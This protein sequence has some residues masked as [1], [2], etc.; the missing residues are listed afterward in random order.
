MGLCVSQEKAVAQGLYGIHWYGTNA[1]TPGLVEQMSGNQSLWV[2]EIAHTNETA[3]AVWERLPW[4]NDNIIKPFQAKGHTPVVRLQP[5]WNANVPHPSDPY[6]LTQFAA[7]AKSAAESAKNI[8]IWQVGN[9]ANVCGENK[10]WNPAANNY[11]GADW[12]PTARQ[13]AETYLA[14]R[15]AIHQV[16]P[17][18]GQPQT[19]LLEPV[20]PGSYDAA[21]RPVDG[22]VYLYDT[23]NSMTDS[24]RVLI[25]GFAVH[26]YAG[27]G[28]SND[29]LNDF[30]NTLNRQL[31]IIDQFGLGDKPVFIT[32]WNMHMPD[33]NAAKN[34]ARF[35][36]RAFPALNSQNTSDGSLWKGQRSH[37]VVGAMWFVYP[38][39]SDTLA[40]GWN[41]YSL[42]YWKGKTGDT[43]ATGDPYEAFKQA[44][45]AGYP[46]GS[47]GNVITLAKDQLWCND[48]FNNPV[49]T[50]PD[51]YGP[52][53]AW[54]KD[55]ANSGAA[56]YSGDGWLKLGA[57]S[58]WG[59]A[60]IFTKANA[61]G[62]FRLTAKVRIAN[63]APVVSGREANTEIRVRENDNASLGYS[64]TFFLSQSAVHS[65]TI[66]VRTVGNW[67]VVPGCD[68]IIPG[69]INTGDEFTVDIVAQDASIR[70]LVYRTADGTTPVADMT[71]NSP[72]YSVGGI[73]L[74]NYCM[75]EV[76]YDYVRLGGVE[77]PKDPPACISDWILSE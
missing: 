64:L 13:Y 2:L 24:E 33:V 1:S 54:T 71:V 9:E 60:G 51:T 39:D 58:D 41:A 5:Y 55:C 10:R 49:G 63:G 3:A 6:G 56:T 21:V 70:F 72:L 27:V 53:P 45:I 36:G 7:D 4:R 46:A 15:E 65:G 66:K 12:Q 11:T 57:S 48:E 62:N 23:L 73:R 28:S 19:C 16:V 77:R 14:V 32:E 35:I 25:D 31:T 18:N 34:A 52:A 22:Y 26:A 59:S 68:V 74:M 67:Q 61:F 42:E 75:R 47:F 69:G 76:Q 38:K 43:S 50:V 44:C 8:R 40:D 30:M 29:G 20:S 37:P 17:D